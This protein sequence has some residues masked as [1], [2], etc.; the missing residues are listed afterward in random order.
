MKKDGKLKEK[1]I[2]NNFFINN[3]YIIRYMTKICLNIKK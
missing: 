3:K 1:K 2:F